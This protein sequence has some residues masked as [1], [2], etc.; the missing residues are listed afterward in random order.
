MGW[1]NPARYITLNAFKGGSCLQILMRHLLSWVLGNLIQEQ[2]C[3]FLAAS[4][5]CS[6]LDLLS[7]SIMLHSFLTLYAYI[8]LKESF[9]L[10]VLIEKRA[11]DYQCYP[12]RTR[13]SSVYLYILWLFTPM[14]FLQDLCSMNLNRGFMS[15]KL[16]SSRARPIIFK[17][18][19]PC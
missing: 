7:H 6:S 18:I 16:S 19:N 1:L 15:E 10:L 9:W 14:L 8:V 2:K 11:S 5:M 3:K 17:C 4:W 13:C 12:S